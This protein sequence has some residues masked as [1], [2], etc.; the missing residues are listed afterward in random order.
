MHLPISKWPTSTCRL[1]LR[2]FPDPLSIAV[3]SALGGIQSLVGLQDFRGVIGPSILPLER[4]FTAWGLSFLHVSALVSVS[5][6]S[7]PEANVCL[8][9]P[10]LVSTTV[11]IISLFRV[12]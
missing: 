7:G 11:F 9:L 8:V 3:R 6:T 2:L 1:A 5:P 12:P 10:L 4:A